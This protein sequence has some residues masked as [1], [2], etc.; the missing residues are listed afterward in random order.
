M[1]QCF[2][3]AGTPESGNSGGVNSLTKIVLW[4]IL[5]CSVRLL[6]MSRCNE[7]AVLQD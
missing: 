4:M 1:K 6:R 7:T 3:G 5:L 2:P